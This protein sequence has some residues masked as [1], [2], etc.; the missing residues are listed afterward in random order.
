MN[1]TTQLP[2][3]LEGE[4]HFIVEGLTDD[5]I[6]LAA[7]TLAE[8]MDTWDDAVGPQ[9]ER[10][11][12]IEEREDSLVPELIYHL[13]QLNSPPEQYVQSIVVKVAD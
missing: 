10:K 7:K 5:V 2:A 11:D 13:V 12:R 9:T 8:V 4:K 6:T 3:T 1:P